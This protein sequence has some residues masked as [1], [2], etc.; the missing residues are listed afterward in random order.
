M[1]NLIYKKTDSITFMLLTFFA[2][3]ILFSEYYVFKNCGKEILLYGFIG[4]TTMCLIF[5]LTL[6]KF[7]HSSLIKDNL[8]LLSNSLN[9]LNIYI[10]YCYI[11]KLKVFLESDSTV[12]LIIFFVV[13]I[14][15]SILI[16]Q[17][18]E[19]INY[20]VSCREQK[21]Y[22]QYCSYLQW[23]IPPIASAVFLFVMFN[24]N[25]QFLSLLFLF[26]W[27][28]V[29][30]E[31]IIRILNKTRLVMIW[32]ILIAHWIG[33]YFISLIIYLTPFILTKNSIDIV[34]LWTIW[35]V[36]TCIKMVLIKKNG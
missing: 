11:N 13:L 20:I 12:F 8:H 9:F 4:V 5:S 3:C 23:G 16:W 32:K 15:Q 31:L 36:V 27:A 17:Q 22:S 10:L 6:S 2:T 29:Y 18:V 30:L 21:T 24:T 35:F 7:V 28:V 19:L 26:F 1:V 14:L 34:I 25:N 33:C